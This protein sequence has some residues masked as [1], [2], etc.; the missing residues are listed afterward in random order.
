M[1]GGDEK[2]CDGRHLGAGGLSFCDDA[3]RGGGGMKN[4]PKSR[5]VIYGQPLLGAVRK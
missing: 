4:L 5:D 1:R 2:I 3:L